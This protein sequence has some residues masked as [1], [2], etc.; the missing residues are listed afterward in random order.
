M[1]HLLA[2]AG[3]QAARDTLHHF[4]DPQRHFAVVD[5][6]GRP[7]AMLHPDARRCRHEAAEVSNEAVLEGPALKSPWSRNP[8][9]TEGGS[10]KIVSDTVP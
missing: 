7:V 1:A 10:Q 9:L 5:E 3:A 4:E 6:E 8:G 2:H